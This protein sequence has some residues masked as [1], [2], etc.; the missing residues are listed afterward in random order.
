M[1]DQ[2]SALPLDGTTVR[3]LGPTIP[4]IPER[5]M[6]IALVPRYEQPST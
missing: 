1:S 6:T 5:S 3:G 2:T 4:R